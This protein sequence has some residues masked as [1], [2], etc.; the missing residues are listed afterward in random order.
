M[1]SY[2]WSVG[3]NGSIKFESKDLQATMVDKMAIKVQ[4][5]VNMNSIG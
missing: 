3:G 4:E 1:T 5:M 2:N